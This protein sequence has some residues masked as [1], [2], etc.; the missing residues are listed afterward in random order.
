M[1]AVGGILV[2][3]QGKRF[4]NELG[5]RDYV[6]NHIFEKCSKYNENGPIVCYLILNEQSVQDFGASVLGF[7]K[8]NLITI[9]SKYLFFL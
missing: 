1:R 5:L 3:Q 7:Y 8:C 4:V 2:N 9:F 6:T